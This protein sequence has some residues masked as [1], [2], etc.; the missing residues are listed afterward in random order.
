MDEIQW[1][2]GKSEYNRQEI[3]N[4]L[5]TQRA[6][7]INDTKYLLIEQAEKK[8]LKGKLTDDGYEISKALNDCRKVVF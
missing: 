2:N 5:Q 3:A 8:G 7:I 1:T 6:M 4:M